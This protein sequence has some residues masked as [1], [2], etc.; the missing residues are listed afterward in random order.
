MRPHARPGLEH[1][2]PGF[3]GYV[4]VG[5]DGIGPHQITNAG[6][7][8]ATHYIIE[9]LGPPAPAAPMVH[10]GRTRAEPETA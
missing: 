8:T 5:P 1:V 3:V 7:T 9:L 6:P 10:N 2:K 4:T